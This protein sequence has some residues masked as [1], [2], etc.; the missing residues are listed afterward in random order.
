VYIRRERKKEMEER[1]TRKSFDEEFKL[2]AVKMVLEGNK[3]LSAVARDLGIASNTLQNWKRK[4][5]EDKEKQE[6]E[7]TIDMAEYKRVLKEN[8]V[9]KEQREILKKAVEFFSQ[10]E[11]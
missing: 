6:D 8:K 10:Y 1:R 5:V 4:Y 2:S 7:G 11:K 9:L 3:R